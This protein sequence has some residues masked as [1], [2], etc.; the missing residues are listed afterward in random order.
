MY[1]EINVS[2]NG[3]HF[4]ATAPRS[5]QNLDTLKTVYSQLLNRFPVTEN[6]ALSVSKNPEIEIGIDMTK[7]L[8]G[9]IPAPVNVYEEKLLKMARQIESGIMKVR[10][11]ESRYNK[12]QS[13][14]VQTERAKLIALIDVMSMF[15]INYDEFR[16]IYNI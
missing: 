4:F 16:W 12:P 3:K 14:F 7:L 9:E 8:A 6:F 2:L 11:R 13:I 5:I 1:Y 10:E 15:K